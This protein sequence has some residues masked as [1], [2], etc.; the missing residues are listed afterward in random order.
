MI[1]VIAVVSGIILGVLSNWLYDILCQAGV[2]PRRPTL[3][4]VIIVLVLSLP[5]LLLAVLPEIGLLTEEGAL[6]PIGSD[7]SSPSNVIAFDCKFEAEDNREIYVADLSDNHI[8][9]VT[10]N[11]SDDWQAA[12]S[13]DGQQIAFSS[14]R[15]GNYEIYVMNADGTNQIRLT[16]NSVDDWAPVWSHDGK[17]ITFGSNISEN[18]G[19]DWKNFNIRPDGT[20][21]TPVLL[22]NQLGSVVIRA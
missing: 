18:Y 9:N 12:W 15:D 16:N 17:M 11:P 7:I 1:Y 6:L 20:N 4:R 13:P 14:N 2:F 22:N 19:G 10:N 8:V 3:K 21:L 5:L